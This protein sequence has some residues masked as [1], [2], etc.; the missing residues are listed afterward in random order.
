[1][2]LSACLTLSAAG[3]ANTACIHNRHSLLQLPGQDA[4]VVRHWEKQVTKGGLLEGRMFFTANKVSTQLYSNSTASMLLYP[5]GPRVQQKQRYQYSCLCSYY[6][7]AATAASLSTGFTTCI[8]DVSITA[9]AI[10]LFAAAAAA[11]I[12]ELLLLK[13]LKPSFTA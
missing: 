3:V 5:V 1:V 2:W 8:H 10:M 12:L 9:T 7:T 4:A 11:I 6:T 13:L